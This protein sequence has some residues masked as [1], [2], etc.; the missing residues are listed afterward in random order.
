MGPIIGGGASVT[1][2]VGEA[3]GFP[4][5][6]GMGAYVIGDIHYRNTTGKGVSER[7]Y[8]GLQRIADYF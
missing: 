2:P 3:I 6:F 4:L 5:L 1:G 8:E 7:I